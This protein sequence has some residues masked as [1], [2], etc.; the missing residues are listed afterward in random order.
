MGAALA[1]TFRHSIPTVTFGFGDGAW[2][3]PTEK[4][5]VTIHCVIVLALGRILVL[6]LH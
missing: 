6:M 5:L 2:E 4:F 3:V 1:G